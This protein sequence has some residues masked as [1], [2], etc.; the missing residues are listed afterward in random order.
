MK[1]ITTFLKELR[2]ILDDNNF[3]N[4]VVVDLGVTLT[5]FDVLAVEASFAV[6]HPSGKTDA[7]ICN[8]HIDIA[9]LD[10]YSEEHLIKQ[11]I[12]DL[13]FDLEVKFKAVSVLH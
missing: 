8:S 13:L 1:Q 3:S 5:E 9:Y 7:L 4:A 10:Q 2:T 12:G 6:R 11:V